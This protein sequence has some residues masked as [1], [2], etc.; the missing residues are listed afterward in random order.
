MSNADK[1]GTLQKEIRVTINPDGT[2]KS[3]NKTTGDLLGYAEK[4]LIGKDI[5]LIFTEKGADKKKTEFVSV[6]SH[7]MRTPL[8]IMQECVSIISDGLLGKLSEDQKKYVG[9]IRSN[10]ERLARLIDNLLDISK[11]EAGEGRVKDKLDRPQ[12]FYR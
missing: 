10:I 12:Q 7:E 1:V 9:I 2:I 8:T 5:G 4:E 3:V 6:V 11:I